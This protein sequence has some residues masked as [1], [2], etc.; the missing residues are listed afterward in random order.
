MMSL[1]QA[2]STVDVAITTLRNDQAVSS[3]TSNSNSSY[4]LCTT[5][6]CRKFKLAVLREVRDMTH[7]SLVSAVHCTSS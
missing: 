7:H 5:A 4:V 6:S 3:I 1:P 2:V